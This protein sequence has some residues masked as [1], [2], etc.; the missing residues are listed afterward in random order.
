MALSVSD[1]FRKQAVQGF[2]LDLDKAKRIAA[3][4]GQPSRDVDTELMNS[5]FGPMVG[6][7]NDLTIYPSGF[8]VG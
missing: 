6:G 7:V 2:M 8:K 5:R 4:E 1:S 3:N